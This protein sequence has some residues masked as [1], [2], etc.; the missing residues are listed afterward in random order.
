MERARGGRPPALTAAAG[1]PTEAPRC[2]PICT[3]SARLDS[4]LRL[5]RA[6]LRS[7]RRAGGDLCQA[8]RRSQPEPAPCVPRGLFSFPA[9]PLQIPERGPP[10]RFAPKAWL[11]GTTVGQS[12]ALQRLG[13]FLLLILVVNIDLVGVGR[14]CVRLRLPKG[15]FSFCLRRAGT[16]LLPHAD[17]TWPDGCSTSRQVTR[18]QP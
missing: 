7:G 12:H 2:G 14:A 5:A 15:H 17:P 3:L 1:R 11:A 9:R 16:Y 10:T 4:G 6:Q 8:Q 18:R 13:F